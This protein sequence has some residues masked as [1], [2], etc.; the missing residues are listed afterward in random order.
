MRRIIQLVFSAL[1]FSGAATAGNESNPT[2]TKLLWPCGASL[3]P[4]RLPGDATVPSLP[5]WRSHV[6]DRPMRAVHRPVFS[7][8]KTRQ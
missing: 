3:L 1:I 7:N 2:A 4:C 5:Y 8:R 6:S